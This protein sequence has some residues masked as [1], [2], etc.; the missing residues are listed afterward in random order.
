[1]DDVHLHDLHVDQG[2]YQVVASICVVLLTNAIFVLIFILLSRI[3]LPSSPCIVNI[4]ISADS[5]VK[6]V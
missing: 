2:F 4:Q 3:N 5:L 1:M 6:D